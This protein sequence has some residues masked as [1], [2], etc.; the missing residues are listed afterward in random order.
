[1][2]SSGGLLRYWFYG[3]A[4]DAPSDYA[5]VLL[6]DNTTATT[7]PLIAHT[8]A[9]PPYQGW[10]DAYADLTSYAGRSVTLTFVNHE[11]GWGSPTSTFFDDVS[12]LVPGDFSVSL[13]PASKSVQA[14]TAVVYSVLTS[15]QGTLQLSASGLPSGASA[16]FSPATVTAGQSATLTVSTTAFTSVGTSSFTVTGTE[17]STQEV[18]STPA[19]LTV[20]APPGSS[21]SFSYSAIS[22]NSAQQ[23]TTNRD[24]VLIAGQTLRVG[25]C[26]VAGASGTGDTYLRLYGVSATQVASSNDSCGSLSYLSYTASQSGTYQIRAGCYSSGSCSG[27]VAYT[28]Q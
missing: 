2:P 7:T 27:T 6:T 13:Q 16:S 10:L 8:Y 3:H 19:Q 5:A 20:T 25:T 26:T 22:T 12:L 24:V 9:A 14:S 28:I 15:G 1:M 17:M 18:R 11:E 23:N 21:G 4:L